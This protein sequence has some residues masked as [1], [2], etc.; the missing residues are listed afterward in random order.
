MHSE[1]LT[2]PFGKDHEV[3]AYMSQGFT[4]LEVAQK[5]GTSVPVVNLMNARYAAKLI[6]LRREKMGH[7]LD[8]GNS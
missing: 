1:V 8:K 7:F 4:P 6:R 5:L 3:F 2:V